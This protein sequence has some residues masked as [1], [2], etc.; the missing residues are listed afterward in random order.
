MG[1]PAM[2]RRLRGNVP[3]GRT[4]YRL[5]RPSIYAVPL[6]SESSR[7]TRTPASQRRQSVADQ[8]SGIYAQR[9][10]QHCRSGGLQNRDRTLGKI[11]AR[12]LG[13]TSQGQGR[14]SIVKKVFHFE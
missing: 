14:K 4:S 7:A 5:L 6:H 12:S 10:N 8:V 2:R 1:A 13:E 9:Q 3:A 11:G